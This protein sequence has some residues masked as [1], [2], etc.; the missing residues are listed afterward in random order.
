MKPGLRPVPE[1]EER[2]PNPIPEPVLKL[3]PEL[4]ELLPG[5][6]LVPVVV[7]T[8]E[9]EAVEAAAPWEVLKPTVTDPSEEVRV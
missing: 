3:M 6:V 2:G 9:M 7:G 8:M 1:P 5:P 4:L